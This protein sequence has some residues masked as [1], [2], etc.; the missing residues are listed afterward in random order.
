MTASSGQSLQTDGKELFHGRKILPKKEDRRHIVGGL[1]DL[2]A[3]RD[4]HVAGIGMQLVGEQQEQAGLAGAVA[5]DQADLL[6][7]VQR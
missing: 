4:L 5:A 3:R 2:P 6:T 7:G 1:A